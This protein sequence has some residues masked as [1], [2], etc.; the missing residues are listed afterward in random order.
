MSRNIF[1]YLWEIFCMH[2]FSKFTNIVMKD[3]AHFSH[4]KT[5]D[6]L[7]TNMF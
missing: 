5:V 1:L 6:V 2:V 7:D 4:V 3:M